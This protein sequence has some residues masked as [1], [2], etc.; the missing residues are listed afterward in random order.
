MTLRFR[1]WSIQ[2][3]LKL[4]ESKILAAMETSVNFT[5]KKKKLNEE[6]RLFQER[7]TLE[8]FLLKIRM[9]NHVSYFQ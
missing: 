6:R 4:E 9:K 3:C 7:W 2:V 5:A 8:Y 1:F